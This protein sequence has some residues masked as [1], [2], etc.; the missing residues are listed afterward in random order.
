MV[1]RF[2]S[3]LQELSQSVAKTCVEKSTEGAMKKFLWGQISGTHAL[4]IKA[5]LKPGIKILAKLHLTKIVN[6]HQAEG[7]VLAL[8]LR[9]QP[10][11]INELYNEVH[12]GA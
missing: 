8:V 2:L 11:I 10:N 4:W 5:S 1:Q 7:K 3:R 9:C 12:V 6:F